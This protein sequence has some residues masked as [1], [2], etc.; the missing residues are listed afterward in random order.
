MTKKRFDDFVNVVAIAI[1]ILIFAVVFGN[2][3][4][5]SSRVNPCLRKKME[6]LLMEAPP[7]LMHLV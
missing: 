6:R 1:I 2:Q 3:T 7:R 4:M 5:V